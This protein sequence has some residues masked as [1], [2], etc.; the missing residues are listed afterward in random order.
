MQ[1]GDHDAHTRG[2]HRVAQGDA[3]AVDVKD[4]LVDAQLPGTGH[5]LGGK[6]LVDFHQAQ[7]A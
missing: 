3:A 4:F 6:G 1:Q 2:A 5:A 7:V